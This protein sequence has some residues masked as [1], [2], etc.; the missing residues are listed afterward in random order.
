MVGIKVQGLDGIRG[1]VTFWNDAREGTSDKTGVGRTKD[2]GAV[3]VQRKSHGTPCKRTPP[4]STMTGRTPP[5]SARDPQPTRNAPCACA[6]H[7]VG[8]RMWWTAGTTRGGT[9]HLG[10]THRETQ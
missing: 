3:T 4:A 10:L 1:T 8:E 7:G 5:A 9:R 2:D 6:A